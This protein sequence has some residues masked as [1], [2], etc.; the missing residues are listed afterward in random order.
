MSRLQ[1]YLLL[2]LNETA[3]KTSVLDGLRDMR[4]TE[5]IATLQVRDGP[6]N[7]QYPGIGAG[8]QTQPLDR[9]FDELPRL[10]VERAG[11]ADLAVGH[12]GIQEGPVAGETIFLDG[13]RLLDPCLDGG[14]RFSCLPCRQIAVAD[15]G[16][17]HMD[18][19][20]VQ[21]GAGDPPLVLADLLGRTAA[22]AA[23]V[24]EK[25]AVA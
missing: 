12:S 1:I 11:G 15:G 4:G 2:S 19:D 8:A 3:I 7:L 16:D 18:V 14:G 25:S 6:G 22:R 23:P 17:L 9:H 21:Q 13:S 10:L 5:G 20:P 24:S